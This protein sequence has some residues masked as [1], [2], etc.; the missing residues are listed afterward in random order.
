MPL[1]FYLGHKLGQG[2]FDSF[3]TCLCTNAGIYST[4]SNL[5]LKVNM[6]AYKYLATLTPGLLPS[7]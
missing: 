2:R 4:I 7:L 5:Q 1:G 6:F 3:I